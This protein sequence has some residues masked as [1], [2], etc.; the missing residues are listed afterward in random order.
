MN[1]KNILLIGFGPHSKR[2]YYPVICRFA[3]EM[4]FNLAMVVELEEKREDIYEYFKSNKP[5]F[6]LCFI[7]PEYQ[8]FDKL[9]PIIESKL[10]LA[11]QTYKID[12]VIIA[13]EP[14]VHMMYAKWALKSRLSILMDKPISTYQNISTDIKLAK[15]LLSDFEELKT[16]YLDAKKDSPLLSFSLMA[17]RRF[18]TS[19]QLIKQFINTCTEKTNCP[20]TSIQSYHSDGQWRMPTEIVDQ[21]YHPYMQ[22]YGKCSHSGYHYFDIV[23]FLLE[24][25]LKGEKYYDNLEIN[26]TFTRPLDLLEQLSLE[27]YE[28]LFGSTEFQKHNKYS[29]NQLEAIM[30]H[31]GEVDA[32]TNIAFKKGSKIMTLASINLLH[33]GFGKRD[34]VT[35]RG[36]DLYRGNGR[37]GHEAHIIQQGPFQAIYFQS[38]KSKSFNNIDEQMLHSDME[39]GSESHLQIYVFRNSSM[40]GGK[41]VEVFNIKELDRLGNRAPGLDGKAKTQAI[42]EFIQALHGLKT[43]E[44]MTSDFLTHEAASV[45][46]SGIYQSAAMRDSNQNACINLP[47]QTRSFKGAPMRCFEVLQNENIF[48]ASF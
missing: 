40:I 14:L 31:F 42:L 26:T 18:Q 12:G 43:S 5:P 29:R 25:G 48:A 13:T 4:D 2:I 39:V 9:H 16:L 38:Y 44:E 33:N 28:N 8:T 34:W 7:P 45:I 47:Y 17:Q 19:F 20:V 37:V 36:R 11:I 27:D 1:K 41:E 32:F 46:I 24:A 35:A 30:T 6:E 23:P 10:D 21:L 15:K 3:E 22:G